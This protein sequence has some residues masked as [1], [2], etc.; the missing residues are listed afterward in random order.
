LF[1]A[2][3]K[4]DRNGAGALNLAPPAE[5]DKL[6]AAVPLPSVKNRG[7][8]DGEFGSASCF[9][10]NG[11]GGVNVTLSPAPGGWSISAIDPFG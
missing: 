3:T 9:F 11:Q 7:C 10:G 1:G 5:L 4:S 6:F 8:D 2:W